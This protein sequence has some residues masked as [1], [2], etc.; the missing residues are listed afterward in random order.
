MPQDVFVEAEVS[1][2]G[3]AIDQILEGTSLTRHEVA[4]A[5]FSA[6]SKSSAFGVAALVKMARETL[7]HRPH[8]S[9]H[10]NK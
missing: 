1:A 3:Q 9:V 6:A 10:E 4:H 7:A 8:D 2:M 5:V